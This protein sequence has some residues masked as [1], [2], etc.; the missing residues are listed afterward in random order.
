MKP[1]SQRSLWTRIMVVVGSIGLLAGALDPLE[2]SVVILVGSGLLALGTFL[3]QGDSR[4]VRYRAL[5]FILIA[6]GVGAMWG[7][8]A[9]GGFGGNSGH[10]MWWGVLILPYLIGWLM[11]IGGP[12]N[13]RWFSLLGIGVGLWYLALG[14][15]VLSAPAKASSAVLVTVLAILGLATLGSC[16][17]RLAIATR[18]SSKLEAP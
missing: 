15:L 3:G 7:L 13:P 6:L 1:L 17:T 8:T 4:L 9:I 11:G 16:V 5:V 14:G 2:G 10:S 18:H 12:G